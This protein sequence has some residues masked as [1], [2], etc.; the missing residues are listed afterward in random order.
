VISS[1][2]GI[3]T[4][5]AAWAHDHAADSA[6]SPSSEQPTFDDIDGFFDGHSRHLAS[7]QGER[8]PGASTEPGQQRLQD[9]VC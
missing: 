8:A 1:A 7:R 5:Y 9:E 4:T 2:D 6:T 3:R